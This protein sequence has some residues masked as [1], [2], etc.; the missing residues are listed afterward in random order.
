MGPRSIAPFHLNKL[1]LPHITPKGKV[2]QE[3]S[4]KQCL[5]E[6]GK[7]FAKR[8]SKGPSHVHPFHEV[9]VQPFKNR[10]QSI[11]MRN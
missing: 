10:R 4:P 3:V 7:G 6:I 2:L 8:I 5:A 9:E 1:G 11:A